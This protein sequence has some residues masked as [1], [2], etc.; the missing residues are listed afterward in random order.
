MSSTGFEPDNV[1]LARTSSNCKRQTRSLVR[2]GTHQHTRNCLTVTKNWS[3][4]PDWGLTSRQTG[5]LT[6]E[7][8]I[9]LTLTFNIRKGFSSNHTTP[10]AIF[11]VALHCNTHQQQQSHPPMITQACPTVVGEMAAQLPLRHY[12][13]V[14]SQSI[15]T[16]DVNSSSLK[17]MFDVVAMVFQ[18]IMTELSEAN[19]DEER[20]VAIIKIVLRHVK[21]N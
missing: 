6:V 4:A 21:R 18:Q 13:Q 7:H 8:N 5:Q 10:G 9:T 12:Q 14:P 1:V 20:I 16:P 3:V 15:Q 11:A 19:S 2:E 17:D